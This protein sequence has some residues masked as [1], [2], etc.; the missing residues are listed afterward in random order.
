MVPAPSSRSAADALPDLP[1]IMD[2]H[3]ELDPLLL[4]V[5]APQPPPPP[6]DSVTEGTL[7]TPPQPG[8]EVLGV[9]GLLLPLRPHPKPDVTAPNILPPSELPK[10]DKD[11]DSA[12]AGGSGGSSC[13]CVSSGLVTKKLPGRVPAT[14]SEGWSSGTVASGD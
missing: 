4:P 8:V 7:P 11:I 2:P 3:A 1:P 9:V 5:A 6:V 12:W 13:A 10:L 14:G